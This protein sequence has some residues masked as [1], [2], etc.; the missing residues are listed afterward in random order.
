[1]YMGYI[2]LECSQCG[3]NVRHH[4]KDITTKKTRICP[5]CGTNIEVS[6]ILQAESQSHLKD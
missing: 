5:N 1:M 3:K 6:P 4:S 2:S